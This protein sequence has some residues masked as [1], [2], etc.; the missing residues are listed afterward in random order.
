M[1]PV[2][3]TCR[4]KGVETKF[5]INMPDTLAEAV[6]EY[7]EATVFVML[8]NAIETKAEN[9]VRALRKTQPAGLIRQRMLTWK[10]GVRLKRLDLRGVSQE[11]IEAIFGKGE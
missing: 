1:K 5:S 3:L 11:D 8:K 6:E 2:E 9:A 4:D 7:G 10:P